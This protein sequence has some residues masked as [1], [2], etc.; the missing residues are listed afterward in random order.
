MD[1]TFQ[2]TSQE[3][4]DLIS[5]IAISRSGHGGR[6]KLPWVFTEHGRRIP[7]FKVPV[8]NLILVDGW[9]WTACLY[10]PSVQKNKWTIIVVNSAHRTVD[11]T[12]TRATT[13]NCSVYR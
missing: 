11:A 7:I 2:L 12:G 6:R 3:F 13:G 9:F 10:G 8:W 4:A 5:R 1:F